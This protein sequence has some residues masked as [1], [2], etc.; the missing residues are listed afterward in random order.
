[1]TSKQQPIHSGFSAASTA[2]E[3]VRDIDL[4]GQTMIV[5]GGYSG[6][7]LEMVRALAR[8]GVSIVVPARDATR[9]RHSLSTVPGV[10]TEEL[11]LMNPDSVDAFAD[12][13]SRQHSTLNALINCA[14]IMANPLTRD[15]RGNESQLS[16]NHLGHFQLAIRLWPML[17]AA[18][19]ARIVAMSS[20]GHRFS[21]FDFEDPN[22]NARPYDR[23]KAY[24]QSKT[25]N[26]LF[27]VEADRRGESR[28]IRAFA[29]H[30]GTILTE[31]SRHL[32]D[33][34]FAGYGLA[35]DT[36]RGFVPQGQSAAEGGMFKT[37][38]QGAATA[39]WCATSPQ[40]RGYGGVYCEDVD[41]AVVS[42]ADDA[43]EAGVKPWAVDPAAAQKLWK[44][45]E[46]LT[47][48]R[49]E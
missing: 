37:A 46:Q 17:A 12:R 8:A 34:D 26:V 49:L 10:Q 28:G 6:L 30:P 31:L 32:T 18:G 40:L 20:R 45:S 43:N 9:A 27:A 19:H 14:G 13:F 7:G 41:I 21:S 24:G 33:E 2:A 35:R 38:E 3:V 23:W 1:M 5:T 39:V 47:G 22:F 48:V 36:P 16:T 4:R 15:A 42:E 44:L 29:V 25:A 11:D